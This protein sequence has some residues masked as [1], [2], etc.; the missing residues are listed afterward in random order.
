MVQK[1]GRR[2]AENFNLKGLHRLDINDYLFNFFFIWCNNVVDY[3]LCLYNKTKNSFLRYIG[4]LNFINDLIKHVLLQILVH[5][6]PLNCLNFLP[7][8][9]QKTRY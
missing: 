5:A 9:C 3:L 6:Q 1:V 4:Y 8:R 7:Y 2:I